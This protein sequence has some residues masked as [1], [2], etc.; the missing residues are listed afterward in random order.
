L[1]AE[2]PPPPIAAAAA[3]SEPL[4]LA[5]PAQSLPPEIEAADLVYSAIEARL[6]IP[7]HP[8]RFDSFV[9]RYQEAVEAF[10]EKRREREAPPEEPPPLSD[11]EVARYNGALHAWLDRDAKRAAFLGANESGGADWFGGFQ[12]AANS[13]TPEHAH[14]E[15]PGLPNP[16]AALAR[17]GLAEGL[18]DLRL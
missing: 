15:R 12:L 7:V 18:S 6:E 8:M 11:E 3:P 16:S 9:E 14:L 4:P 1:S 13:L 5:A 10:E 17:P 2:V